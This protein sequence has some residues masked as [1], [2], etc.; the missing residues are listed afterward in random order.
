MD[1]IINVS[2]TGNNISEDALSEDLSRDNIGG[3]G[4]GDRLL[5]AR[6]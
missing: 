6:I 2:F 5:Y 1:K 4:T 3:Y